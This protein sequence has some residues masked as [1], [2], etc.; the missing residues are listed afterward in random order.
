MNVTIK[1]LCSSTVCNSYLITK[2]A[3]ALSDKSVIS[4]LSDRS[5]AVSQVSNRVTLCSK[6][7]T[8][9]VTTY[10]AA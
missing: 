4:L 5:V 7:M 6:K 9:Q 3:P 1:T 10:N 8:T 2:E